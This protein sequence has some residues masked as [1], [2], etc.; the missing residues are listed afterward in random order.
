MIFFASL[1]KPLFRISISNDNILC[2]KP[3]AQPIL[4]LSESG[5]QSLQFLCGN[6]I[7]WAHRC[8]SPFALERSR[9]DSETLVAKISNC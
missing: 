7:A 3:R 5:P 6:E 2:S 4:T 8:T 9:I 1:S